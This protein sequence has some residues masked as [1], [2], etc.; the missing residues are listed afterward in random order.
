[1]Q[2]S[3]WKPGAPWRI[4]VPDGRVA[5]SGEVIE[6]EPQRK[7]VLTW[8]N[9]FIPEMT[10]EGYSRVVFDLEQKGQSVKLTVTHTMEMAGSKFIQAVANGWPPILS[11]LKSLLETG[12][13]LEE[14][15]KWPE[16]M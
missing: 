7:L 13:S 9:E 11:S 10:A 15:R 12:A 4:L 8:R 2:E 16:G 6:I 5:D 1:V 3:E 14:T